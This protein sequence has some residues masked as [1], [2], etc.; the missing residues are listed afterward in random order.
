MTRTKKTAQKFCEFNEGLKALSYFKRGRHNNPSAVKRREK[1]ELQHGYNFHTAV[2]SAVHRMSRTGPPAHR[3]TAADA[4]THP[5]NYCFHQSMFLLRTTCTV[6]VSSVAICLAGRSY[7][8]TATC[9]RKW[10]CGQQDPRLSHRPHA[11]NTAL[12]E[13]RCFWRDGEEVDVN[14]VKGQ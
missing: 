1:K 6:Q 14:H 7:A 8:S 4:L 13:E 9:C 12:V 3:S 10:L 11:E 2:T 5:A